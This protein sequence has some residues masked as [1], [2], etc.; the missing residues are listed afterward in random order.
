MTDTPPQTP[1]TPFGFDDEVDDIIN[2]DQTQ[3]AG[4][5]EAPAAPAEQPEPAV[6]AETP[7]ETEV[8]QS[9]EAD[10]QEPDERTVLFDET[11]VDLRGLPREA[12]EKLLSERQEKYGLVNLD[13][14][15]RTVG[16]WENIVYRALADVNEEDSR[17]QEAIAA[18]S[19][20]DR[21]SMNWALRDENDK[22][23]LR[24]SA[25]TPSKGTKG[26][27]RT[28]TGTAALLA[29]E[30]G[31][32]SNPGGYRILLYNSGISLDLVAPTSIAVQ[33]LID[34]CVA[35]DRQLG[36]SLGAHYFAHDD[37]MYKAQFLQFLYPLIVQSSYTDWNK[38]G[39]LWSVIKTPDL[40]SLIMHVAAI[41]YKH[42]F[43][44]F[45][46]AC[47]RPID[48]E[49]PEGCHDVETITAN[50]FEMIQTRH[51]VMSRQ[52]VEFMT[53]TRSPTAKHNL[54]QIGKYQAELGLEGEAITV[55]DITFVMKIPSLT[56]HMDAGT[57]FLSDIINEVQADN[58]DGIY[59]QVGFR[60]IRSYLPWISHI[61]RE[62]REGGID[63]TSDA[64]VIMR[65]IERLDHETN[66]VGLRQALREY[67]DK[68]Q[69]TYVG[70]PA[71]QCKTCGYIPD[72]PSGML[73]LD[74]FATFFTM[75]F[76]YTTT[77]V[78]T[79]TN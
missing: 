56:E 47:P 29:F 45:M 30:D 42:G 9:A 48:K 62:N 14:R 1:S 61:E 50:L 60:R 54:V 38:K 46:K 10:N 17:T 34:N 52:A 49:H 27:S 11:T 58:S 71:T 19:E 68:V 53:S 22:V 16:S 23:V 20:E 41:V 18:L 31:G 51:A 64:A 2:E 36:G 15:V 55:G 13:A 33:T 3:E 78:S 28:L 57:T 40:H 77:P 73:T 65:A 39:K 5:E 79:E 43:D 59:Q 8:G 66:R 63:R 25:I 67:I 24:T 76:R 6:E 32:K 74:P 70:Y 72:T 35:I 12:I 26:E 44:N 37:Q 7:D 4:G 75:A 21:A 69:L